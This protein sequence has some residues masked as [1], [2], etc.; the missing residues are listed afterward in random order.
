MGLADILG[1]I[2]TDKLADVYNN[3]SLS[4][5]LNQAVQGTPQTGNVLQQTID[6]NVQGVPQVQNAMQ[7]AIDNQVNTANNN[8]WQDKLKQA[9]SAF[10]DYQFTPQQYKVSTLP[11]MQY[12][13]TKQYQGLSGLLKQSQ[14][15]GVLSD[16]DIRYL[17]QRTRQF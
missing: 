7:G 1:N 2:N 17:Q 4:A 14:E 8:D 16:N 3:Q 13:P 12:A 15:R 10:A 9:S 11:Q 6:N 5:Q